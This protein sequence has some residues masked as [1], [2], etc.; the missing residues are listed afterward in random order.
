MY[1]SQA[2]ANGFGGGEAHYGTRG[3][4]GAEAATKRISF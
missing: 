1:V 2:E 3:L 4:G